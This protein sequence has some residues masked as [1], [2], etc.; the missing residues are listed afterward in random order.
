MEDIVVVHALH[1]Q[2]GRVCVHVWLSLSPQSDAVLE[3]RCIPRDRH[4]IRH[5]E[6]V[7]PEARAVGGVFEIGRNGLSLLSFY[8]SQQL[9]YPTV[10]DDLVDRRELVHWQHF[11]RVLAPLPRRHEAK[12]A[13]I[14]TNHIHERR[15]HGIVKRRAA[16]SSYK[17]AI[18]TERN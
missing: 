6:S 8:A 1:R 16:Y 5:A 15:E 4:V 13:Q 12:N 9:E 2:A 7:V 14:G 10:H 18:P 17:S 3:F 11:D